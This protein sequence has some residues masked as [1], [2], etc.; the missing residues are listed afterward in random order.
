MHAKL[1]LAVAIS[2]LTAPLMTDAKAAEA[3]V[4]YTPVQYLKNF[5]LSV[6][7][8]EGFKAAPDV[9]REATA[10][11]GGYLEFGSFPIEGAE[12]ADALAKK[13]LAKEYLGIHGDKLTLMKCIDLF[14]SK[15]LDRLG[16]KYNRK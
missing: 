5:A 15:E 1:K 4:H 14:H 16:R 3:R 6:C 9:A 8:G 2:L 10:A 7:I 11:A 13:Y 12:Q